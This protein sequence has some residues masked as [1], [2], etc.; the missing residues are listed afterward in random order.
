MHPSR[1]ILL[2]TIGKFFLHMEVIIVTQIKNKI[3]VLFQPISC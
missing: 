3:Q 2:D 1:F